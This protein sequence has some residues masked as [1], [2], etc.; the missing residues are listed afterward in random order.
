MYLCGNFILSDFCLSLFSFFLILS[1]IYCSTTIFHIITS[2]SYLTKLMFSDILSIR[3]R[4]VVYEVGQKIFCFGQYCKNGRNIPAELFR[5]YFYVLKAACLS[6]KPGLS[7]RM[8]QYL[9]I[10]FLVLHWLHFLSRSAIISTGRPSPADRTA[11][12]GSVSARKIGMYKSTP[13]ER[14]PCALILRCT[15]L[16]TR[17][18]ELAFTSGLAP[19]RLTLANLALCVN[20]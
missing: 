14:V 7:H 3:A 2:R 4:T 13:S 17:L 15:T 6:Q 18:I 12:C 9:C 16:S 5:L 19:D 10:K 1:N 20:I 8:R 11:C